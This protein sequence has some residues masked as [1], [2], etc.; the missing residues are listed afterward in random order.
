MRALN[1]QDRMEYEDDLSDDM[2]QDDLDRIE[3][4][5]SILSEVQ[6]CAVEQWSNNLRMKVF[7]NGLAECAETGLP[8]FNHGRGLLN[9][10]EPSLRV[11]HTK[12]QPDVVTA[13]VEALA[14]L[15]A[16]DSVRH[17]FTADK[18]DRLKLVV[19]RGEAR[20]SVTL[21]RLSCEAGALGEAATHLKAIWTAL[22]ETEPALIPNPNRA[23][24]DKFLGTVEEVEELEAK[25]A[26]RDRDA[27]QAL[28]ALKKKMGL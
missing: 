16:S 20:A 24:W 12:V 19:S 28:I 1:L 10:Y 27:D 13:L 4:W 11:W 15:D 26:K 21:T 23:A 3:R 22:R 5:T 25:E 2:I 8:D 18:H 6:G 9:H 7:T 14:L 17:D